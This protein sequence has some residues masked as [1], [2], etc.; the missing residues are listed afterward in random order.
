MRHS[1]EP[2]PCAMPIPVGYGSH[3]AAYHM[4]SILQ[5]IAVPVWAA[6]V[7]ETTW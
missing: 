4:Y 1:V 2:A 5:T 6:G 7:L 3:A